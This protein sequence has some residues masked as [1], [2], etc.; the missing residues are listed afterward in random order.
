[1]KY[2]DIMNMIHHNV[3]STAN[4]LFIFMLLAPKFVNNQVISNDTAI[5]TKDSLLEKQLLHSET[6][7][8]LSIGLPQQRSNSRLLQLK[9]EAGGILLFWD[10]QFQC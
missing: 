5:E 1:M 8:S 6:N 9:I 3:M 2:L 4:L 7:S 10:M